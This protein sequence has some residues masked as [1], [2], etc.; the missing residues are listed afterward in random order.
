MQ[1]VE[2]QWKPLKEEGAQVCADKKWLLIDDKT[3]RLADET[4]SMRR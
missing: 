1:H 3:D 2:S 4:I